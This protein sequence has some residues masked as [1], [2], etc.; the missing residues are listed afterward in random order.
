MLLSSKGSDVGPNM[1]P[2]RMSVILACTGRRCPFS[3]GGK[4]MISLYYIPGI[5]SLRQSGRNGRQAGVKD[6]A[7]CERTVSELLE[8]R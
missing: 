5:I 6:A 8:E 1:V 4:K 3:A 7:N 2:Y